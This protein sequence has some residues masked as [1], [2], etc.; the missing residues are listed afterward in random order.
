MNP[1]PDL[2][3]IRRLLT[4]ALTSGELKCPLA[5]EEVTTFLVTG[6]Y[7]DAE[8]LTGVATVLDYLVDD[9]MYGWDYPKRGESCAVFK[10]AYRR[11][12]NRFPKTPSPYEN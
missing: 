11:L 3:E 6:V 4:E 7:E 8:E 9:L 12:S 5:I 2:E 10:S 1:E